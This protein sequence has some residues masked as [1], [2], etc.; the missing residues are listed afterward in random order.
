M[1]DN[2]G[3]L[4]GKWI[5]TQTGEVINIMNTVSDGDNMIIITDKGQIDSMAF[6]QYYV[7]FDESSQEDTSS[8]YTGPT[9]IK[10]ME[11]FDSTMIVTPV[12]ST[13]STKVSSKAT[14]VT[15][16]DNQEKLDIDNY[17]II[18]KIFK[19]IPTEPDIK[20]ELNWNELPVDQ[21]K[22]FIEFFD[23]SLE[24]IAKYIEETY[25]TRLNIILSIKDFLNKKIS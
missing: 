25:L 22:T 10:S 12:D 18:D 14:P 5:N 2:S 9:D 3:M 7:Q 1:M 6:S 17:E 13:P 23:L 4:S 15:I 21:I 8:V 16:N 19:K 20:I 11:G 24:D